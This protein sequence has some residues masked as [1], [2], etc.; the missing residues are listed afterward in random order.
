[1]ECLCKFQTILSGTV[2][3]PIFPLFMH[4]KIGFIL[5]KFNNAY[6]KHSTT[7][8]VRLT[9]FLW[10]YLAFNLPC[11]VLTWS[12]K[13]QEFGRN[14]VLS[15]QGDQVEILD[16]S[17]VISYNT[18]TT[19]TAKIGVERDIGNFFF[20]CCRMETNQTQFL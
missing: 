2:G 9:L 20:F 12:L 13:G 14:W 15:T 18:K 7:T 19:T 5:K 8:C 10:F 17:V 16:M 4:F 11:F 1:M 3:F 6:I